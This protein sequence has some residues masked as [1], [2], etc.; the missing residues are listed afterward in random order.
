MKVGD[1]VRTG[2]YV[3]GEYRPMEDGYI[4]ATHSGYCDV[5]VMSHH[6]GAPWIK[7]I[8]HTCLRKVEEV[9]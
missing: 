3:L 7:K 8:E 2:V 4:V 9:S 1:H 5:D 6:G